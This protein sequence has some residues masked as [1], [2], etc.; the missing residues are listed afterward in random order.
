M[1]PAHKIGNLCGTG[2]Y[3]MVTC[4]CCG[5]VFPLPCPRDKYRFK[6]HDGYFCGWTC[7]RE[8]ERKH[9]KKRGNIYLDYLI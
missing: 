7:K 3:A 2:S 1:K 6:K 9:P 8:W 4:T 5:K